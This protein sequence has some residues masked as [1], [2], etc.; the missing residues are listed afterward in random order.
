[1]DLQQHK[2]TRKS[3]SCP[4]CDH[5]FS[6]PSHLNRHLQTHLPSSGRQNFQCP[7]CERSFSRYDVLLRHQRA[8]HS[9]NQDVRRSVQ[10]SCM[11]CV[12]KKLKCDRAQTC[13]TCSV[14]GATCSYRQ[15]EE[16]LSPGDQKSTSSSN[17]YSEVP[18][19]TSDAQ[20]LGSE[21]AT[22]TANDGTFWS[23]TS[24]E[25][26]SITPPDFNSMGA[27]SLSPGN[28][29][30]N[31]LNHGEDAYSI[32]SE[33]GN[34]FSAGSTG[35][36]PSLLSPNGHL[37][38]RA[39]ALDWLDFHVPDLVLSDNSLMA[40][41]TQAAV[42]VT[43]SYPPMAPRQSVQSWPFDQTQDLVPHRYQLPPLRVV[44]QGA[45]QTHG[46]GWNGIPEGILQ[47]LSEPWLPPQEALH[48]NLISAFNLLRGLVDVY[49]ARFHPIQPVTHIP[50]WNLATCPTVLLA[51]MA[52][53]GAM[54]SDDPSAAELSEG[55]SKLCIPM[56]TWLVS[57]SCISNKHD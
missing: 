18:F 39:S 19:T 5:K 34:Y 42:P 16:P 55:L 28:E 48:V 54:L 2:A 11:R 52:C 10:K 31:Q 14:A 20:S 49:F 8:A 56:M 32:V 17:M 25:E 46:N 50:T 57:I 53:I 1:M 30:L 23:L 12:Q 4:H 33:N 45:L 47:L 44:L 7:G 26:Q 37:D 40:P 3:L 6:R 35:F 13:R 22:A 41:P 9:I 51:A 24:G 29:G 36:A 15:N 43:T 38:F 27:C 21:A